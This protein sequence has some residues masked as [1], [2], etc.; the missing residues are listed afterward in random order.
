MRYNFDRHRPQL[1]HAAYSGVAMVIA[2]RTVRW[3]HTALALQARQHS[4]AC[5]IAHVSW[6]A[7]CRAGTFPSCC[8]VSVVLFCLQCVLAPRITSLYVLTVSTTRLPSTRA[9]SS[10]QDCACKRACAA[11]KRTQSSASDRVLFKISIWP[12]LL[13][14]INAHSSFPPPTRKNALTEQRRAGGGVPAIL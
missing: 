9:P 4:L 14:V 13:A 12:V 5:K 11:L 2:I 3:S 6:R 8:S 7:S 1:S 10:G